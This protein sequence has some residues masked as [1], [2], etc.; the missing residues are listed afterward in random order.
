[1]ND[2]HEHW[3]I[4]ERS[5]A[6][7][8]HFV[9]IGPKGM[10]QAFP[11]AP[12]KHPDHFYSRDEALSQAVLA[13]KAPDMLRLLKAT[14]RR[15]EILSVDDVGARALLDEVRQGLRSIEQQNSPRIPVTA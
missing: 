13:S 14:E 4:E 2:E 1:V 12:L 11:T 10:T 5:A 8:N 7:Y 9:L 3:T 6:Q 15:L